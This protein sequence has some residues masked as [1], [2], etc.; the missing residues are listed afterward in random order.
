MDLPK[1]KKNRLKNYDYSSEGFYYVTICTANRKKIFSEIVGQGL[2]PAEIK[3]TGIGK[4]VK[5]QLFDLEKRYNNIKIEKH[6]VMPDHIHFILRIKNPAGASPRPTLSDI[7]C[8]Y[9]SIAKKEINKI[10]KQDVWQKGFYD[11]I[12]RDQNDYNKIWEYINNNPQ[13]WLIEK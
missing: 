11:H 10:Y 3:L 8:T 12:I 7:I 5:E 13:K 2:A 6:V 1:R 4:I 9:K